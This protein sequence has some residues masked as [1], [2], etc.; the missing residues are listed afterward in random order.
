MTHTVWV[1]EAPA[2]NIPLERLSGQICRGRLEILQTI[3]HPH[4]R[5]CSLTGD[6][7]LAEA[8]RRLFPDTPLPPARASRPTGQPYLPALPNL[9]FSL[10]HSGDVVLCALAHTPVGIDLELPRRVR[11]GLAARWFSPEE[12]ALSAHDPDA[13]F[14]LWMSKE[15]VLKEVGCGISGGLRAV[16]VTQGPHPTAYFRGQPHALVSV[17]LTHAP[18]PAVLSVPGVHPPHIAHTAL[19][20]ANFL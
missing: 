4:A 9:H 17:P 7:L 5:A 11:P 20:F 1:Y 6:L 16:T 12:A 18:V 10:S 15:A 8:L 2:V 3:R 13:F 19:D 14:R